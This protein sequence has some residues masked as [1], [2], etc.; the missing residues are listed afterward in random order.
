M[1][2]KWPF[3]P[4]PLNTMLHHGEALIP[5]LKA[6]LWALFVYLSVGTNLGSSLTCGVWDGYS[7]SSGNGGF[8]IQITH[9]ALD[10]QLGIVPQ[11]RNQGENKE[12]VLSTSVSWDNH[13]CNTHTHTHTHTHAHTHDCSFVKCCA[14]TKFFHAVTFS[15]PKQAMKVWGIQTQYGGHS[16]LSSPCAVPQT[17]YFFQQRKLFWCQCKH[18]CAPLKSNSILF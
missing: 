8:N 17:L 3:G 10:T 4:R 14:L 5:S 1:G 9:S 13:L 6:F 11:S 2:F 12:N 15:E 7:R 16:A 18:K